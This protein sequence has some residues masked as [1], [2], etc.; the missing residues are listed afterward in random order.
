MIDYGKLEQSLQR[1]E[2]QHANHLRGNPALSGLDREGIA[3]SVI[4][5]FETCY[6]CLWKV[7]KRHLIE[8]LGVA[9]PPN[10]PK[11]VFRIA[12]ESLRFSTPLEQWLRY[13]DA[14]TDTSHDYDGEKAKACLELV[15]NFIN[16][17]IDLYETMSGRTWR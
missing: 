13:A 3:E 1:L 12:H 7:L 4:Q 10:S 5:R 9:D 11:P 14:R 17:T 16:D 2:E 15:P 6:D 8:N